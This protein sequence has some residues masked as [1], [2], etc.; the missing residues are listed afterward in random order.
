[1][2]VR[3]RTGAGASA[4]RTYRP[5]LRGSASRGRETPTPRTSP[6]KTARRP[7]PATS[8]VPCLFQPPRLSVVFSRC[9]TSRSSRTVPPGREASATSSPNTTG[10]LETFLKRSRR[11]FPPDSIR[12]TRRTP[13]A[14]VRRR[15][16]CAS[17][18]P[19]RASSRASSPGS[20]PAFV[21]ETRRRRLRKTHPLSPATASATRPTFPRRNRTPAGTR[22]RRRRSAGRTRTE[23]SCRPSC[24]GV[25]TRGTRT[26]GHCRPR[27]SKTKMMNH[28]PPIERHQTRSRSS[29]LRRPIASSRQTAFGFRPPDVVPSRT[30]G[31]RSRVSLA[32]P[33]A[34]RVR[35][36]RARSPRA[37]SRQ[38]RTG[39]GTPKPAAPCT[40]PR[41]SR[42]GTPA[43]ADARRARAWA[44]RSGRSDRPSPSPASRR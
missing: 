13:R 17:R 23:R 6:P 32:P 19:P 27:S 4:R 11:F 40:P 22:S 25:G 16:R 1:M 31:P 42:S 8:S 43:A 5:K 18:K 30:R 15:S 34:R 7:R 33:P 29:D 44:P 2:R 38:T 36:P 24:S 28:Q 39:E 35:G 26:K 3:R 9:S 37:R 12:R 20:P 10:F 14:S 21:G 41:R